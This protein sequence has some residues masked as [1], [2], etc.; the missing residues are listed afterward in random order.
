MLRRKIKKGVTVW[1][2]PGPRALWLPPAVGDPRPVPL[3]VRTSLGLLFHTRAIP[4]LL[5]LCPCTS[6]RKLPWQPSP[7]SPQS[8]FPEG[9]V[10]LM[11]AFNLKSTQHPP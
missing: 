7:A 3:G 8:L 4:F 5:F 6:C 1:P 2:L 10:T 11:S 9:V